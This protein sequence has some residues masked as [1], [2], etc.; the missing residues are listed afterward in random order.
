MEQLES[1]EL[2]NELNK[3]VVARQRSQS[4][5]TILSTNFNTIEQELTEDEK[6]RDQEQATIF[7]HIL[8]HVPQFSILKSH[9]D[10]DYRR[11]NGNSNACFRV[12]IRDGLYAEQEE[13]R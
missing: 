8:E 9:R 1:F 11:L 7:K 2:H 10:L 3:E 6:I 5:K 13:V 4:A 12:A